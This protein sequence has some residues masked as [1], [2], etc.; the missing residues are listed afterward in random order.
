MFVLL[1]VM[2]LTSEFSYKI[3]TFNIPVL[4]MKNQGKEKLNNFQGIKLG[5]GKVRFEP[6]V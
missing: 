1:K 5:D 6:N 3:N 4:E 2:Y